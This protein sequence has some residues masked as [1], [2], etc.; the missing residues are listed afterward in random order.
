MKKK[1]LVLQIL[2]LILAIPLNAQMHVG[3]NG[4]IHVPTAD[5]D[6][7]G[8]ARLGINYVPMEMVPDGMT[9]DGEKFN[10]FTHY[11]SVTPFRWIEIGYG[12]T[13]WKLHYNK[14][15]KRQTGFY[16]KDRYFSVKIQAIEEDRWWPS[17][18]VGGN[19]VYG[20]S[21]GGESKSNYYRN[22]FVATSKHFDYR[23][24]IF[25]A[26]MAYRKWKRD[27]NHRWNG[28]VGGVTYQPSFYQ[29]LRAMVEWDGSAVNFGVDCRI[30]KY[31]FLQCGLQDCQNFTGGLSLCFE[32]L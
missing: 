18:V 13:L 3:M 21:D 8:L 11:M 2:W 7:V 26:H 19:D 1:L 24:H 25:G 22:F 15:P 30:Y 23:G 6:T 14:N 9:C 5:M 16:A 29:P 31:F 32:L 17:L 20:S 4:L 27:Y 12:C 28:V 10:T